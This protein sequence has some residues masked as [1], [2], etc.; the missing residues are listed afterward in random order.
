MATHGE[1]VSTHF[2]NKFTV[3]RPLRGLE[4]D[5]SPGMLRELDARAMRLRISRQAIIKRLLRQ[6]LNQT[7]VRSTT[8]SKRAV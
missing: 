1:D 3:V 5:L 2:P 8:R 6:A 4:A 7:P